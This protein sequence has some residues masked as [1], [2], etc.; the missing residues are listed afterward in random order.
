MLHRRSS[1]FWP[2]IRDNN[3]NDSA[4]LMA[5]LFLTPPTQAQQR[6]P[7][8]CKAREIAV[9]RYLLSRLRVNGSSKL[10]LVAYPAAGCQKVR[11]IIVVAPVVV[12]F[13]L[14]GWVHPSF[15][16]TSFLGC[17]IHSIR[18]SARESSFESFGQREVFRLTFAPFR[19]LPILSTYEA[20]MVQDPF[21][22]PRRFQ[23]ATRHPLHKP[24]IESKWPDRGHVESFGS[25]LRARCAFAPF[26]DLGHEFRDH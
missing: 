23:F 6:T 24:R 5:V 20:D 7:K 26:C 11:F 21:P 16:L 19:G 18:N 22:S 10:H 25:L 4:I 12:R 14:H 2:C 13:Q 15:R 8:P 3:L 17:C 9:S 1:F